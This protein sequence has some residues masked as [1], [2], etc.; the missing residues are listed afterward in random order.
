MTNKDIE[1]A[2][3]Q[4]KS[5][6]EIYR[7]GVIELRLFGVAYYGMPAGPGDRLRL[8]R[9]WNRIIS[10]QLKKSVQSIKS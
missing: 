10:M 3:K 5:A 1:W 6:D 2:I 8:Q 7:A 9:L 4:G